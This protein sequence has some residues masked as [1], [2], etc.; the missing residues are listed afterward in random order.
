MGSA[1]ITDAEQLFSYLNNLVQL[2]AVDADFLVNFAIN[3]QSMERP[4]WI[5]VAILVN[6]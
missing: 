4:C 5:A 6:S 1:D 3:L 2:E